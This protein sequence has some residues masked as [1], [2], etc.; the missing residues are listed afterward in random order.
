M[1]TPDI[2]FKDNPFGGTAV[3]SCSH[4]EVE[5]SIGYLHGYKGV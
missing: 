2:K 4:K 5:I 1:K 3:A